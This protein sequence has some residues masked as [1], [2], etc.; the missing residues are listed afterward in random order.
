M[1]IKHLDRLNGRVLKECNTRNGISPKL[2]L[3]FNDSLARGD[4]PDEWC[5]ANV[6][7]VFKKV[8]TYD[9]VN[10]RTVWLI[11]IYL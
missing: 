6:S 4:V 7:P 8:E 5:G 2:A 10:H 1:Y 9:A 11:S 3:Y